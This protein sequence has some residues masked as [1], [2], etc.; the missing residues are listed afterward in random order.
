MDLAGSNTRML[1][2]YQSDED[3]I[4]E[5]KLKTRLPKGRVGETVRP[6]QGL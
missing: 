2:K 5:L 3:L 1:V 6:E 4:Q